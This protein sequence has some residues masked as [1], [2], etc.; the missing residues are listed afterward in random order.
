[1]KEAHETPY[2]VHPEATKMYKDLKEG[3]WW[4]R[5]KNDVATFISKCLTYQKVKAEHHPPTGEL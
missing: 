3:F 2:S 4:P 1:M 5:M